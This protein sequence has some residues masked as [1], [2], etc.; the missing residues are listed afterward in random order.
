MEIQQLQTRMLNYDELLGESAQ[1]H[2]AVRRQQTDMEQLRA[3]VEQQGLSRTNLV[4]LQ[5]AE[6][7]QLQAQIVHLKST[8]NSCIQ[9]QQAEIQQLRAQKAQYEELLGQKEHGQSAWRK[10][11]ADIRQLQAQIRE[12]QETAVEFSL[13]DDDSGYMY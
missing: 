11:Q 7:D 9:S 1:L 10:Q 3:Q 4:R 2:N 8:K 13:R 6:I 5:Q 12:L